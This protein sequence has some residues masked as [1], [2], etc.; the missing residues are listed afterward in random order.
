MA[1][2]SLRWGRIVLG[3][4]LA[5]L[6]LIIAVIP[7]YAT[8]TSESVVTTVAVA[9]SFIVFVLL[10]WWLARPTPTPVLH[11]ILM[12][13]VAALIYT[14]LTIVGRQFNPEAP[15]TPWLY[16]VAH[17]LKLAGGATGGWLS[18]LRAATRVEIRR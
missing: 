15:P 18:T 14:L 17:L 7:I 10:A 16:Y 1:N 5:E 8:G 4:I 6:L 2:S 13:A 3:G 11:G 9:G 12:G